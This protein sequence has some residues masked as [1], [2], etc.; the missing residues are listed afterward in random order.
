MK[1]ELKNAF[2]SILL[3]ISIPLV[4]ALFINNEYKV[5]NEILIQQPKAFVF[6]Y[7]KSLRNQYKFSKW[8]NIDPNIKK[9]YSG[10]DRREVLFLHGKVITPK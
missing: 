10:T 3:L 7:V 2:F 6:T 4:I 1:F 8:A 9:T 5:E